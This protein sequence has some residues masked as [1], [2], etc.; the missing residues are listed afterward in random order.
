METPRADVR[1]MSLPSCASLTFLMIVGT[2]A[3]WNTILHIVG[4]SLEK[5]MQIKWVEVSVG[6]FFFAI[7]IAFAYKYSRQSL[8]DSID[9]EV[10]TDGATHVEE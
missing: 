10:G 5:T 4:D 6:C 9:S 8:P 2:F 1:P 7:W 3:M